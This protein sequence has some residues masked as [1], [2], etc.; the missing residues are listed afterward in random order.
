MSSSDHDSPHLNGAG[1]RKQDYQPAKLLAVQKSVFL[2]SK[3][4]DDAEAERL[5]TK[6]GPGHGF[7]RPATDETFATRGYHIFSRINSDTII[8]HNLIRSD[9]QRLTLVHNEPPYHPIAEHGEPLHF[10]NVIALLEWAGLAG[11]RAD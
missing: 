7:V 11:I 2:H 5:L 9:T 10:F 8:D 3:V 6:A 1:Y 4:I